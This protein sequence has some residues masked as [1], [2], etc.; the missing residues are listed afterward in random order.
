MYCV[1]VII[2]IRYPF[3]LEWMEGCS[4][5]HVQRLLGGEKLY[6]PPSLAFTPYIYSPLYFYVS[7]AVSGMLGAS[8]FSLRLVSVVSSLA[9]FWLIYA[10]VARQTDR[11]TGIISAGL[12]VATFRLS[13]AWLD[14][15]R[16]DSLFLC[17]FLLS[18]FIVRTQDSLFS[19]VLAA[20]FASLS[21]LTKQTA[22]LMILPL[23][24]SLLFGR[25]RRCVWF[26]VTAAIVT[27]GG[28]LVL[29]YVHDGWYLYY[30]FHLPHNFPGEESWYLKFWTKDLLGP[31]PVAVLIACCYLV[32]EFFAGARDNF[33]F[34]SLFLAG[35][36]AASCLSRGKLQGDANVLMPAYAALSIVF[37]LGL[38]GLLRLVAE[39]TGR[40]ANA[41]AALLYVVC[42]AQ[43]ALL[44]YD[45]YKQLPS[46]AD[47][48]AGEE[49][50]RTVARIEGD[51][52]IP[53]HPYLAV[54]AGKKPFA[55][56]ICLRDVWRGDTGIIP[57][58][59][60]QNL[61]FA[62]HGRKFAAII[63]DGP[64]FSLLPFSALQLDQYYEK[65]GSFLT[66][67]R[68]FV[69][70][71]GWPAKPAQIYTPRK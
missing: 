62:I 33:F 14:L 1:L 49:F 29:D 10:I 53:N 71:T 52:F 23:A 27:V 22:L 21:L 37:G 46:A 65:S 16:V 9:C 56:S 60:L 42:I 43:F 2:R 26:T 64:G 11:W 57:S 4:V 59:L 18:V 44:K 68:V 3:E 47:L 48:I 5:I 24:V 51:V 61:E 17:L 38:H 58:I 31:L 15:A 20:M 70:V 13:G 40:Y 54:M 19:T 50:V 6:V 36:L 55:L 8:L 69:P 32:R 45:P 34:Y 12:F 39:H 63:L 41:A 35:M 7:A 30:S 66:D 67:K 25:P 28:V